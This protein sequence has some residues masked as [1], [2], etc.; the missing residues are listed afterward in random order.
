MIISCSKNTKKD[1]IKY[2]GIPENKIKVVYH[3]VDTHFRPIYSKS[4]IHK[5]KAKYKIKNNYII[6][7]SAIQPV[8]NYLG[9]INA[10]KLS[11]T[12]YFFC[13]RIELCLAR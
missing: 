3:G 11:I 2:Y 7:V 9:L 10:F 5:I 4:K 8:K 1:I 12:P 6:A 13:S